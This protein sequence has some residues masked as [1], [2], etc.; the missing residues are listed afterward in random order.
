MIEIPCTL[1]CDG[2]GDTKS[3]VLPMTAQYTIHSYP[4]PIRTGASFIVS[5]SSIPEGWTLVP[6]PKD[7]LHCP[8]CNGAK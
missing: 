6:G 7:K 1:R 8:R 3:A 2:C 5:E 4:I